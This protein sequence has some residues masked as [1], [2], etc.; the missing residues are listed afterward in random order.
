MTQETVTYL[1]NIGISVVL[2]G[3]LSH[4]WASQGR[5]VPMRFWMT[6]A[7]IMVLTNCLFASR[8][9]LPHWFGRMV[10]TLLVTLAH[11]VLLLGARATAGRSGPWKVVLGAILLH[12]LALTYF[13]S[14]EERTHW[15]MVCNGIVWA[16][17]SVA[18]FVS[19]RQSPF[20]FWR[21]V[22]S[23]ANVFIFHAGFHLLRM[24]LSILSGEFGWAR[25]ANG[26]QLFGDL[27]VSVFNVALY[28]AILV[29]TMRQHY[30]ELASTR[31]EMATLSGLLPICAW[32]KKVRDDD[33]Y[34]QQVD[35]YFSKR[36]GV[37]F[38]H[39]ICAN[40]AAERFPENGG[41]EPP[42][43]GSKGADTR[44]L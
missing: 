39:G 40:C 14:L 31:V 43:E 19:F 1:T 22:F 32:C 29:A 42:P 15:R 4:S 44:G 2:A 10:P 7:W 36:A 24:S 27:E 9:E 35:D 20:Y 3:M 41:E 5:S 8:P 25:V 37:G 18:T 12:G 28:V 38:T 17:L 33:G 34:W 16:S 26:L 23:P 21:S 13:L 6:A 11:G 30:E